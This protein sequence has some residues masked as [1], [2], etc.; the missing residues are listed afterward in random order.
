[1]W[2]PII[3]TQSRP[4]VK[5]RFNTRLLFTAALREEWA[6]PKVELVLV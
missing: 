1:M 2:G 3:H 4:S 5:L 6:E